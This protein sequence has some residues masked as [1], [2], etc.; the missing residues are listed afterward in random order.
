MFYYDATEIGD[1]NIDELVPIE[2]EN[3]ENGL[4][5]RDE[6][7]LSYGIEDFLRSNFLGARSNFNDAAVEGKAR[8]F[9]F[10]GLIYAE[11]LG[12]PEDNDKAKELWAKGKELGDELCE[13]MLM[14]EEE[15]LGVYESDD[16]DEAVQRA[17]E[18]FESDDEADSFYDFQL[19]KLCNDYE[20]VLLEEWKKKERLQISADKGNVLA[21][22]ELYQYYIDD[23]EFEKADETLKKAAEKR[24]PKAMIKM[25]ELFEKGSDNHT[26]DIEQALEWYKMANTAYSKTADLH[27]G[28]LYFKLEKYRSAFTHMKRAARDKYP[29]AMFKLGLMYLNG[30]GVR[31]AKPDEALEWIKKAADLGYEAAIKHIKEKANGGDDNENSRES[32][33]NKIF[34]NGVIIHESNNSVTDSDTNVASNNNQ[35]EQPVVAVAK[36]V[37]SI[38]Q[39]I[40]FINELHAQNK[41]K[42]AI[43]KEIVSRI[44]G[45]RKIELWDFNPP[46]IDTK[47]ITAANKN[48]AGK[49]YI[50]LDVFALLEYTKNPGARGR[51]GI[52]ITIDKLITSQNCRI[53]LECIQNI[54][55]HDEIM[56][57][58]C[59]DGTS[60]R[61]ESTKPLKDGSYIETLILAFAYFAKVYRS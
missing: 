11:G 15:F 53:P 4:G 51:N 56:D 6:D 22:Y 48:Y 33:S 18:K 17:L 42:R 2:T 57:V 16:N 1:F 25:G 13:L 40:E 21:M 14:D 9:Y 52:M 32:T 36:D 38:P 34:D 3:D 39:Y 24:Y 12:V 31:N 43:A 29:E 55:I 5:P 60:Y 10:L 27:L 45:D 28:L 20:S 44:I 47:A 37:S 46:H 41:A 61:Y 35:K 30:W 49:N 26:V 58:L 50:P 59:E 23:R 54:S 8:A 19:S 7:Y